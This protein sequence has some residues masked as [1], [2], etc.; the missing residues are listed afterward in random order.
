MLKKALSDREY[1]V[2]EN[3]LNK[4]LTIVQITEETDYEMSSED[5]DGYYS[6]YDLEIDT[7]NP[8]YNFLPLPY[9]DNNE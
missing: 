7:S 9:G 6:E 2:V 8:I 3:R 5:D 1:E 4:P